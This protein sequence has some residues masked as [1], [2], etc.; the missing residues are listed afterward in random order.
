M[1]TYASDIKNRVFSNDATQPVYAAIYARVSTDNENQ[2]ESCANQVEM[3]TNFIAQHRNIVL[4]D[5]YIDDGVSAKSD[6]GRTQYNY[7]LRAIEAGKINL[8]VTKS[9]SRLNRDEYNSFALINLLREKDA[10]IY[11]LE[12]SCL[13]D[14]DDRKERIYNSLKIAMDADYVSDQSQKGRMTQK[15]RCERKQLTAKD[16][17]FGYKWLKE[18]KTISVDPKQAEVVNL[19]YEEYVFKSKTPADIHRALKQ[20]GLSMCVRT[21]NNILV[22]ERYIGKFYINKKTT[23]LGGGKHNSRRINLPKNQW[24]LVERDDLRIVDKDLFDMAQKVRLA[25][26]HIYNSADFKTAQARYAGNHKYAGKIFCSCCG[27][28]YRFTHS[29]AKQKV[30]IYR[31]KMH[32]DC[33]NKNTRIDELDLDEIT[34]KALTETISNQTDICITLCNTLK[35]C[36]KASTSNTNLDT[37]KNQKAAVETKIKRLLEEL[38]SESLSDLA[39]PHI[40]NRINDLSAEFE[41]L[42]EEIAT[43]ENLKLDDNYIQSKMA[44]ITKALNELVEFKNIDRDRV[45][46]YVE[47]FNVYVNGDIDIVLKTGKTITMTLNV[48]TKD[49]DAVIVKTNDLYPVKMRNQDDPC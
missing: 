12:D 39:K 24:V 31:L 33:P 46:I 15:L 28:P 37:L 11:T 23:K 43:K 25:K 20:K 32:N 27:K 36:V 18:T 44:D 26:Q 45:L 21:V 48:S 29:D 35:D 22:D 34:K 41:T 16:I 1:T 17:S 30:P 14:F 10:T 9:M 49:N 40:L 47:R 3:A 19:I 4:K 38:S 5:T 7:L 8:I 6:Y 2:K 42:N 13:H